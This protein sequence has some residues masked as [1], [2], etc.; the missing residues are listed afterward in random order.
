MNQNGQPELS[1]DTKRHVQ[2]FRKLLPARVKLGEILRLLGPTEGQ[3]CLTIVASDIL[4][5]Y[6]LHRREGN[7]QALVFGEEDAE[8][9]CS[10]L[11]KSVKTVSGDKVPYK[12][13]TFDVVVVT[14][15]MERSIDHEALI[16]EWHRVLKPAGRIVITT[17]NIK[18][19]TMLRPIQMVFGLTDERKGWVRSGYSESQ[20][21]RV[22]KNGFDVHEVTSFSRFFL[23]F[24][25]IIGSAITSRRGL[26]IESPDN[27][28]MRQYRILYPFYWIAYQLDFL[29]FFTR[30]YYL[31]A[32]AKRRSWLP[33][34]TP[35]LSDGRSISE[36]VLSK[37]KE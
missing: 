8:R 35:V 36:A 1:C 32:T 7:W 24:V 37:I 26:R 23:E 16:A 3:D 19:W 10:V 27:S 12:D 28:M 21:F 6:H 30:G 18:A 11:G 13:K 2:L 22:L 33:R 9:F 14:D 34:K 17:P 15:V 5:C 4:L 20:L 31:A 29:L 25:N